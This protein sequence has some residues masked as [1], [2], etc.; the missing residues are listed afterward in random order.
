L[1]GE[2]SEICR[3]GH[4]LTLLVFDHY[5]DEEYQSG[6]SWKRSI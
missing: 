5:I 6:E 4:I 2:L 1:D 3:E